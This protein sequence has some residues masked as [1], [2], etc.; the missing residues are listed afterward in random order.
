MGNEIQRESFVF[1]RG[2]RDAINDCPIDEQ[3][4]IY[5]SIVDYALD[6]IEPDFLTPFGR[7][8]WRL[9]KP[10]LDKNWSRYKNGC[11]GGEYGYKGG[12][13]KGNQNAKKTTPKRPQNKGK[14]TPNDNV[15]DNVSSNE[16]IKKEICIKKKS[17]I[18]W[19][20]RVSIETISEEEQ[21]FRDG[22]QEHYPNVCKMKEP[23][24]FQQY[25]KL[26]GD[27]TPEAIRDIL[28]RMENHTK[29]REKYISANLTIRNWIKRQK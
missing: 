25:K 2:F 26:Q 11:K 24:T 9:I 29:L 23:L 14:T 7:V 28:E 21:K 19:P 6:G 1:Y 20:E 10:I 22:M 15:N 3:L 18:V 5:K 8:C 13:P 12:A 16:D 17:A 27:Y 4:D